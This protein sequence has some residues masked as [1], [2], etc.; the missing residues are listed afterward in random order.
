MIGLRLLRLV[1]WHRQHELELEGRC[2]AGDTPDSESESK[3][4]SV[5]GPAQA[6]YA[7]MTNMKPLDPMQPRRRP[8]LAVKS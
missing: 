1:H 3:S 7:T 8:P 5:T 6:A 4:S 2:A